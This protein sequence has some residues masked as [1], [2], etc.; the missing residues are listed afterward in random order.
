MRKIQKY[1][2]AAILGTVFMTVPSC[3][4][5]VDDHYHPD[6]GTSAT[7]TLWDIITANPNLS[8]FRQI[9]EKATYYRDETH[10]QANYTFKD[11][12]QGS[13]LITAWIPENSAFTDSTFQNWL[14]IAGTENGYTVQQQLLGN[15]IALWRQVATGGGVDTLTMLNGKK[16]V[17]DKDQFTMQGLPMKEKN[18]AALN[19]TLHTVLSPLPFKYNIYEYL[20][21]ANNASAN[22]LNT[23]HEYLVDNDTTYFSENSS[24]EGNP[25]ING[26]PTYVDSVY[27]TT[28]TMF[29]GNKRFPSET[30]TDQYLTYDESF[31]ANIIAEDSTFIMLL[32]S[33]NAWNNAHD[34]L[35]PYYNYASIYVDKEKQDQGTTVYRNV[36]NPDSLKEKSIAMDITSPLCFNLHYQPN[37]GGQIGRWKLD[38][39]LAEK[40]N[41]DNVNADIYDY[42]EGC[43]GRLNDI[44]AWC[45]PL[46]GDVTGTINRN[47]PVS[48]GNADLCAK[49]TEEY[50]GFSDFVNPEIELSS[51]SGTNGVPDFFT[52]QTQNIQASVYGRIRNI[53]DCIAG[54]EGSSLPAEQKE[55]LLG[56]VYFFRAWAYF[57]LFRWYGGVPLV[58]E[59]LEPEEGN[60][61]PR[62]SAR[63]TMQFI[64]ADLDRAAAMLADKTMNGGW[65]GSSWGRVTTGTAL[66]LKGRVLLWWAS[67]IF[68]RANDPSRWTTAYQLMKQE[69][70]SINA[71]GYGL[72]S[73]GSNVNGSDFAAQFLQ[74]GQNPEAVFVT[75]YNNIEGDGLDNQKNN[76]WER[77]IRPANTGGGGKGAGLMLQ[78][79][80]APTPSWKPRS[81]ATRPTCPS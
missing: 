11:M 70:D 31:G 37:A 1:I 59:V 58:T 61:T 40:R 12:L 30:N 4:D 25:D 52:A 53:N 22:N 47:F 33:D 13:L 68:N 8:N 50:T 80:R 16:M 26:N 3:T 2:G 74:T 41:Y 38:D 10:P 28:N 45:L 27:F 48:M 21:D 78:P 19:G 49:S 73:T 66:A 23:F 42:V 17:F 18:V 75:L 79:E 55:P 54:I 29:F 5:V 62:S 56:Q 71:C 6:G 14:N 20:K 32:P 64:L 39:F 76:R 34:M 72:F 7:G 63:A 77:D 60:F 35:E 43:E 46:V 9:A 69:L 57:N 36:A 51:M 81:T 15:S 65:S 24:I 44:Y 67:P